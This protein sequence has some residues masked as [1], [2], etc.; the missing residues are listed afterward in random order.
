[1]FKEENQIWLYLIGILI[2]F[3]VLV[4]G[5]ANILAPVVQSGNIGLLFQSQKFASRPELTINSGLDYYADVATS[6]GT[7]TI[8]LYASKA[9]QN[10]NN[11]IYLAK[12]GFY[13]DTKFHRIVPNLLIQGGD[14]NTLNSDLT[15]DGKGRTGY[16]IEDESNWDAIDL[17]KEQRSRL[18]T[19]GFSSTSGLETTKFKQYSVA[20]A[21]GG[22]NTNSS[23]FFIIT[24]NSD[25]TR[26]GSLDG[27]YTIIGEITTGKQVIDAINSVS[28][29]DAT[30]NA[31]TP[32]EQITFQSITIY[33]R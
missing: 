23:Q 33:T 29:N 17:S 12:N 7:F 14:R 22:P 31:P 13:T 4:A 5:S 10:V 21:N 25:D 32:V 24:A 11:F 18:T 27:Q 15:D 9:P 26:L 1:M 6:K 19:I 30:L 28:V 8:N 20:M 16:L 3:G 2:F